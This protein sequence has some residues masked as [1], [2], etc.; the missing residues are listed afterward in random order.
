MSSVNTISLNR[1]LLYDEIWEHSVAGVA[2]KY[3]LH[4]AKLIGSLKEADIPYPS[5]GY[6]TRLNCGKDVS[7]EVI[8]LPESDLKNVSLYLA[9]FPV[10]M[11][12]KREETKIDQTK[13]EKEDGRENLVKDSENDIVDETEFPDTL[14]SF[15]DKEERNKVID[16]LKEIKV[17]QRTN[18]HKKIVMYR[19]SITVWKQREKEHNNQRYNRYYNNG[20]KIEPPPF[21]NEVSTEG[22]SRVIQLL[23]TLFKVVEKLGGEVNADLS[24]KVRMDVVHIKFAEGQDKKEHELTK[25]EAKALLEYKDGQKYGRYVSKPQ[26]RKYDYIY[27]GK[28]RIVFDNGKYIRDNNQNRLED[29]LNEILI[30]LYENSE[31][32]RIDRERREEAHRQYLEEKRREEEKKERLEKERINT[33]SLVNNAKDYKIACEIRNYISAVLSQEE[34]S[35]EEKEWISWAEKKADWYDPIIAREDEYLGKRKHSLS[36]D[37]KELVKK[38]RNNF[39]NW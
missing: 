34:L 25:Q 5:S 9:G 15:L 8:N 33:Q 18:F 37:E 23:D 12:N 14:L 6:W 20:Y 32:H 38:G 31:E 21:I 30:Q 11:K 4:Y 22:L 7:N 28:L 17:K 1:K 3:N 13:I 16:I 26:I 19:E 27:N 39:H 35:E 29:K 36:E 24:M 10:S 2:K